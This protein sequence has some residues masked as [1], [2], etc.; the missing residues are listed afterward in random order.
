[1]D[2]AELTGPKISQPITA[3]QFEAWV[4]ACW[5]SNR[6]RD[7]YLEDFGG[8]ESA[9]Y[10]A[11]SNGG[12]EAEARSVYWRRLISEP[13]TAYVEPD[14]FDAL[15][16][17]Q[18]ID[19]RKHFHLLDDTLARRIQLELY[20]D[21][22][23]TLYATAEDLM[24]P[25]VPVTVY[26]TLPIT[27]ASAPTLTLPMLR[28]TMSHATVTGGVVEKD[29]MLHLQSRQYGAY[30]PFMVLRELGRLHPGGRPTPTAGVAKTSAAFPQD[31]Y[32]IDYRPGAYYVS[33]LDGERRRALMLGPFA[34]HLDA[35]CHM[36]LVRRYVAET[37][38]MGNISIGTC[39]MD[40]NSAELPM[41]HLNHALLDEP[42]RARLVNP[43]VQNDE[44]S[45]A[46]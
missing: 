16:A 8:I 22:G 35:L 9:R 39:R 5:A 24:R 42:T 18:Q 37:A 43:V 29:D 3:L 33:A 30:E 4:D 12:D 13:R 2:T 14:V 27:E 36:R 7:A 32:R 40:P 19:A 38:F 23:P 15:N 44:A 45:P 46:P 10:A 41:G 21:S 6:Y 25:G 31:F 20:L 34:Q 26:R 1:M 17:G 28:S 11:A